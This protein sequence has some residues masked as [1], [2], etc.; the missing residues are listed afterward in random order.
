M[1]LALVV[2]AVPPGELEELLG[3]H[4]GEALAVG[5]EEV[6]N[7]LGVGQIGRQ[8]LVDA[9]APLDLHRPSLEDCL[10]LDGLPGLLDALP[11]CSDCLR[12]SL[13]GVLDPLPGAQPE[14]LPEPG[15]D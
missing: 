12:R 3:A 4:A 5:V 9:A 1:E 11:Q 7:E 6:G 15:K 10:L 2:E 8:A 14:P 13:Q